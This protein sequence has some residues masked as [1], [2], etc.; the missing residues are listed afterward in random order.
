MCRLL[1]DESDSELPI[2]REYVEDD[3]VHELGTVCS[4]V[5]SLAQQTMLIRKGK[6]EGAQFIEYGLN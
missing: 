4:I 3:S 1:S 6:D 5:M 2:Y